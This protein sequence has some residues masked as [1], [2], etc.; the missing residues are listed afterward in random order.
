MKAIIDSDLFNEKIK[1][2]LALGLSYSASSYKVIS[3]LTK[4]KE[5]IENFTLPNN[6]L[7]IQYLRSIEKLKK[8]INVTLIK[9]IENNYY[10]E[11]ALSEIASATS[12]RLL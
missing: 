8:K 10:D 2:K 4:D 9:R 12:L 1:E 3:E 11:I 6:T 5:L 7:G